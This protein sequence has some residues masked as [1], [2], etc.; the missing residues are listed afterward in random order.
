ML[1]DVLW[2]RSV[3][4]W[5]KTRL[6]WGNSRATTTAPAWS[7]ID[8]YSELYRLIPTTRFRDQRAFLEGPFE[9]YLQL[10]EAAPGRTGARIMEHLRG[11]L[12]WY[13]DSETAEGRTTDWIDEAAVALVRARFSGESENDRYMLEVFEGRATHNYRASDEE[14]A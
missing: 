7:R 12:R 14:E 3:L 1:R 13:R 6:G 5:L 9:R 8:S 4:S 10:I 2:M 11:S